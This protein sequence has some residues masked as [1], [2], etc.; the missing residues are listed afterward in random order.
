MIVLEPVVDMKASMN[1]MSVV[2]LVFQM[3][4]VIVMVTHWIVIICAVVTMDMMNVTSV[5]DLVS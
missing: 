5:M 2:V 1:V 4:I 3:D